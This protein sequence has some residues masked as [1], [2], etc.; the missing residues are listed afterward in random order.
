[1]V[2]DPYWTPDQADEPPDQADKTQAAPERDGAEVLDDLVAVLDRF[3]IMPHRSAVHAVALWVA[4]THAQPAWTNATRL[5][6]TSPLKRCGK[7][8]LLEL[9]AGMVHE[10]I[11]TSNISAAALYRTIEAAAAPPT[12]LVDEA[13][14]IFGTK[15]KAEQTEDLRSLF[16]SGYSREL[17]VI[18]CVGPLQIPTK[19]DCYAMT[20]L[21]GIGTLPDTI[22]DRAVNVRLERRAPGES[23]HPYRK[24]RDGPK[25]ATLRDALAEWITPHVAVLEDVEPVMDLEDRAADNWEP[26]LAVADLAGGLWPGWAR[27]AAK[28]LTAE[29]ADHDAGGGSQNVE[30][31]GDVA[32]L[33]VGRALDFYPSADLV[34]DLRQIPDQSWAEDDLSQKRLS[35]ILGEFGIRSR[36]GPG[37]HLRGYG[38]SQFEMAFARYLGPKT[39]GASD[40]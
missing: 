1:M 16:N 24:R 36:P 5:I 15:V 30:L 21:A 3:V 25:L 39:S 31:L 35:M 32:D 27:D 26:L 19:F 10:P 13:D 23:V 6:V 9:A 40:A 4:A 22:T 29:H 12:I 2:Y 33:W 28:R 34:R 11:M 18:R 17:P 20:A 7:S 8:R 14:A 38:R 37:G